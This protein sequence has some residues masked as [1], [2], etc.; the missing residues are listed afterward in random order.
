LLKSG[1]IIPAGNVIQN[2]GEKSLNTL[3]LYINPDAKGNATG[4]LYWDRG[5]GWEFKKKQYS[6]IKFKATKSGHEIMLRV[7]AREG[8]YPINKEVAHLKVVVLKDGKEYFG[9]GNLKKG[10]S[11]QM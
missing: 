8:N 6:K 3:T 4:E 9:A 11:V 7:V 10:V 2:T 5:E 1:A